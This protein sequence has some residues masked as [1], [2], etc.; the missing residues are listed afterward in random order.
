MIFFFKLTYSGTKDYIKEFC[1]N[2]SVNLQS[3]PSKRYTV[4][5]LVPDT[6]YKFYFNGISSCGQNLSQ[7]IEAKTSVSGK[8]EAILTFIILLFCSGKEK[9]Y[10]HPSN[11][12]WQLVWF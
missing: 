9:N 11:I 1:D 7:I 12:N 5:D 10:C 2:G 6:F 8:L 3:P 4:T